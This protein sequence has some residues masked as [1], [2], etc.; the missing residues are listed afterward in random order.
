MSMPKQ[1]ARRPEFVMQTMQNEALKA[2]WLLLRTFVVWPIGFM[3]ALILF[4]M[5]SQ[6]RGD[7]PTFNPFRAAAEGLVSFAN[8]TVRD[9][10]AGQIRVKDCEPGTIGDCTP[11]VVSETEAINK[12]SEG[13]AAAYGLFLAISLF[14]AAIELFFWMRRQ[15]R[16]HQAKKFEAE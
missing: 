3:G 11:M 1:D 7:P 12:L 9:V 13:F 15:W 16:Q 10:P 8:Q 2:I 6:A 5:L 14:I 4:A